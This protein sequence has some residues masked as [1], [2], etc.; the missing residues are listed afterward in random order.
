[1]TSFQLVSTLGH[2]APTKAQ[3]LA[4]ADALRREAYNLM[5]QGHQLA[6]WDRLI[7]AENWEAVASRAAK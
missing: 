2:E 4:I 6:G 3:A 5:A 7:S 1:M